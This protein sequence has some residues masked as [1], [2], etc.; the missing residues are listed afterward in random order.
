MHREYK[1]VIRKEEDAARKMSSLQVEYF[2]SCRDSWGNDSIALESGF[3]GG[4]E[5]ISF[6]MI[7]IIGR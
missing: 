4:N 7:G 6:R 2:G 5:N 1:Q 3:T